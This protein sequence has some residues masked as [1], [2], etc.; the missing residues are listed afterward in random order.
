MSTTKG[1]KD[2]K[3]MYLQYGGIIEQ[4]EFDVGHWKL[5]FDLGKLH[6]YTTKLGR[7]KILHLR[8]ALEK[9]I[10]LKWNRALLVAFQPKWQEL[11]APCRPPK[12]VA[13]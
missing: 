8:L 4:L 10:G 3:M 9:L 13:F 7:T 5:S 2:N 6:T 12:K 11:W 1:D